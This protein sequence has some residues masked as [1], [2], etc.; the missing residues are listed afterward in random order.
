MCVNE[1]GSCHQ[2]RVG[3]IGFIIS[4]T[5]S[6]SFIYKMKSNEL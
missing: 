6:M 1:I 4:E 5:Y 2:Q 3:A